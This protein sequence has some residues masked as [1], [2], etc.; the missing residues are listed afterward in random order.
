MAKI[1]I[2]GE[3]VGECPDCYPDN[4]DENGNKNVINNDLLKLEKLETSS[5][6]NNKIFDYISQLGKLFT[7]TVESSNW[8]NE[9]K[10]N[11]K[12]NF[13]NIEKKIK[14]NFNPKMNKKKCNKSDCDCHDCGEKNGKRWTA[15][16]FLITIAK[17]EASRTDVLNY[18]LNNMGLKEIAV[19]RETHKDGDHHLHVYLE[20][21][22]KKNIKSPKYFKLPIAFE[23]YGNTT[24]R[25]DTLGKKT[26]E[27]VFSYLLKEDKKVCNYGF[28]I[29]QDVHGKL[30]QKDIWYKY[31]IGEWNLKDIVMYDP[32]YMTKN[33]RKLTNTIVDNIGFLN[34][35]YGEGNVCFNK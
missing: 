35:I 4:F 32:S 27:Q 25:I 34:S 33:L 8:S 12:N 26:K 3:P 5:D 31:M 19:A 28:N 23:K 9:V 13:I 15:K 1:C 20:F 17:T 11:M 21:T 24:A 10:I 14:S 7:K 29:R 22:A 6:Y 30:K 16:K 18:Y 2:C